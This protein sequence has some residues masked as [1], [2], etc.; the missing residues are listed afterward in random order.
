ML[1][2]TLQVWSRA[3]LERVFAPEKHFEFVRFLPSFKGLR[4]FYLSFR[5]PH[6]INALNFSRFLGR[7]IRDLLS[8]TING[9]DMKYLMS[10]RRVWLCL[11]YTWCIWVA[12]CFW[13]VALTMRVPQSLDSWAPSVLS[14]RTLVLV[15]PGAS[16]CC[17]SMPRWG[18]SAWCRSLSGSAPGRSRPS[19]L[20]SACRVPW[21]HPWGCPAGSCWRHSR[22]AYQMGR[23]LNSDPTVIPSHN[24]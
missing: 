24:S 8:L 14:V 20:P 22:S 9:H 13:N 19:S 11:S 16:V 12:V 5:S 4:I 21:A 3:A 17:S 10:W 2:L 15:S 7:A 1:S 6:S 18:W 23:V